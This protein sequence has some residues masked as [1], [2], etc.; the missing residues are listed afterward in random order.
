GEARETSV[1]P[2]ETEVVRPVESEGNGT[3]EGGRRREAR[4]G[5]NRRDDGGVEAV[6]VEAR[7]G[8][9]PGN[10]RHIAAPAVDATGRDLTE[11]GAPHRAGARGGDGSAERVGAR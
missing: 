5:R 6:H 9:G 1:V 11:V 8:E 3:L 7:L 4:A 10:S 2:A